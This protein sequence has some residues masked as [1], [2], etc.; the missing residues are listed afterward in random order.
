MADWVPFGA[1]HLF[2]TEPDVLYWRLH[3]DVTGP[4]APSGP[5]IARLVAEV[6]G[7]PVEHLS[8]PLEALVDGMVQHGLPRPVAEIYASFDAGFAAGE[9]AGVSDTVERLTGKKPENL[10]DFFRR[11]KAA[12]AG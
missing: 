2:R 12:W 5:D 3:G 4:E 1:R 9:A 10:G 11:T 6:G 8:I 7:R